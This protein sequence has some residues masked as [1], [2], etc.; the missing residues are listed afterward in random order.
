MNLYEILNLIRKLPDEEQAIIF[1]DLEY[2][3]KLNNIKSNQLKLD[4]KKIKLSDLNT[5]ELKKIITAELKLQCVTYEEMAM[6]IGVSIATFKRMIA[7]P[8]MAKSV[9]LHTLLKEL[10]F[11]L[12]LE[13]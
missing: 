3:L 6:Q 4:N 11:K 1:S 10:G 9:N 7:N 5:L 13:K 12:C 8:L 2:H